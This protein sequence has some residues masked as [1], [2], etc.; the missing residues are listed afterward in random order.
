MIGMSPNVKAE[1]YT[2]FKCEEVW[3]ALRT[4]TKGT[5]ISAKPLWRHNGQI[6]ET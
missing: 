3:L 4:T 6:I 2:N 5:D 1:K